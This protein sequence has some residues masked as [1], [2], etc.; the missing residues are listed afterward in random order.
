MI[1]LT[2]IFQAIIALL[3]ALVT[4][5]LVPWLKSKM[6]DSQYKQL[7]VAA[8]IA[9]YA[10]EQIYGAGNGN[11][12]LEYALRLL[13]RQGFTFNEEMLRAAIEDAVYKQV[14]KFKNLESGFRNELLDNRAPFE[15]DDTGEEELADP[16]WDETK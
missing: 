15:Q 14:P 6:T 16:D 13:E 7:R 10:A 1:D 2:P 12:K 8:E 11:Q 9:V 3:A 5:K 4:Y